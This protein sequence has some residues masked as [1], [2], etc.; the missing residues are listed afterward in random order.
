MKTVGTAVFFFDCTRLLDFFFAIGYEYHWVFSHRLRCVGRFPAWAR[1]SYCSRHIQG[2]SSLSE[3]PA[4]SGLEDDQCR[5]ALDSHQ[6]ICE[7]VSIKLSRLTAVDR[8]EQRGNS[9]EANINVPKREAPQDS[10]GLR[11][12][13]D[14]LLHPRCLQPNL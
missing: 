5:R 12:C 1:V 10:V 14:G 3:C 13:S 6:R 9:N 2:K 8:S 4:S 7:S 11:V